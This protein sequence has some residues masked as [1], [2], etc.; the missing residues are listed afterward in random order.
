LDG[1]RRHP[2]IRIGTPRYG[3]AIFGDDPHQKKIFVS[4]WAID[5]VAEDGW[6]N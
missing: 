2:Q 6:A 5:F 3:I 4:Q 1:V